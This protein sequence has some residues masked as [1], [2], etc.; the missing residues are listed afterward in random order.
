MTTPISSLTFKIASEEW[1][2]EQ[3]HRLNYRTFVE[4]IPQH[5]PNP[6]GRL[7]DRFHAENIYLIWLHDR[8][9]AGMLAMRRNRPFSLDAKV[10]NLDQYLPA[11]RVPVEVRLLAVEPE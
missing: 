2:L 4:E 7:V 9:L 5:G 10:A 6:E 8:R 11:G 3:I 1:E